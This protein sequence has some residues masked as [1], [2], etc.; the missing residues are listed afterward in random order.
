M[1][2]V[3]ADRR[4][5]V[6]GNAERKSLHPKNF[7]LMSMVRENIRTVVLIT[8]S[9]F[10]ARVYMPGGILPFG[11]AFFAASLDNRV[12]FLAVAAS[13]SAGVLTTGFNARSVMIIMSI[14]LLMAVNL[15]F[16]SKLK[17]SITASSITV[18]I[19]NV[20]AS[21]F[22]VY[23]NGFLLYDFMLSLL[24]SIAGLAAF[25]LFNNI[26]PLF[27]EAGE[28]RIITPEELSCAAVTIILC[29]SGFPEISIYGIGLRNILSVYLLII[30]SYKGGFG[31]GA[32][33]GVA[34]G[35]L[36]GST[37]SALYGQATVIALYS[38][39]GFMSGLLNKLGKVGTLM[40]FIIGNAS[41]A[42][43]LNGSLEVL[44]S[45]REIAIAGTIFFITPSK[46][47]DFIKIPER[48]NI[49]GVIT[50]ANYSD[51]VKRLTISKLN[52]F[53]DS[54]AELS[55]TFRE[56]SE[57]E[58]NPDKNDVLE[59]IDRAVSRVCLGCS[60]KEH[61]WKRSFYD[62]Y[63]AIFKIIEKLDS[64]GRLRRSDIPAYFSKRCERMDELVNE[65]RTVYEMYKIEVM[66]RKK[67]YESREVFFQ[68]LAALSGL[69]KGL[70]AE[71]DVDIRFKKSSENAIAVELGKAG[72]KVDS[73]TVFENKWGKYEVAVNF[74]GCGGRKECIGKISNLISHVIG[75]KM[76]VISGSKTGEKSYADD[77]GCYYVPNL[78]KCRV[79]FIEE[80]KLRVMTGVAGASKDYSGISGDN[81]SFMDCGDGKYIA[82][83]CD[84]MG[85]GK[86][87]NMHSRAAI[88]L[89]EQFIESG[90][91]KKSA[92]SM[93]NSIFI[94]KSDDEFFST[95][96]LSVIDLHNGE[97][98]FIKHGSMP[99]IIKRDI[100][101]SP[102]GNQNAKS[103]IQ[104]TV[105]KPIEI[106]SSNA[107]PIGIINNM[108]TKTAK[109]KVNVGDFIIMMTDGIY[110]CFGFAGKNQDDVIRFIETCET[111][112][113][114]EMADLILKEAKASLEQ[115]L[116]NEKSPEIGNTDDNSADNSDAV[117]HK[118]NSIPDD[119]LVLVMKI[120]ERV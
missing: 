31:T 81:F 57:R 116:I 25:F 97:V 3:E 17:K 92:I 110:D 118:V 72:Y 120:W 67:L 53:S 62:T 69:I 114:Q 22:V 106:I 33:V 76:V 13:I 85:T 80:E 55:K 38:F 58:A 66:W 5:N 10:L 79:R 42:I 73:V 91:D 119:M 59:M 11:Y 102:R 49:E 23:I 29:I 35:L 71:V 78:K 40:G 41:L 68:Q 100:D 52:A 90:F 101:L 27:A 6:T 84:G 36:V 82:A 65:I 104:D 83:I 88:S 105:L 74:K 21:A 9:F 14:L 95:I 8:L 2:K 111:V 117:Y 34:V 107:L 94:M 24:Q 86:N 45:L 15:L 16:P 103:R 44:M 99:T 20:A 18:F 30:F 39:C 98:E 112:N 93:I 19:C 32:A 50:K 43:I 56:I 46:I 60:L 109:S 61:C 12:N 70:A 28:D 54:F 108:E 4:K 115:K 96:D 89:L 64:K 63:K 113:P 26:M 1:M 87:A 75:K 7:N 37:S 77:F 47:Y 48:M 51:E